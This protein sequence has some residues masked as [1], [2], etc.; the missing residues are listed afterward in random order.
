MK[1]LSELTLLFVYS[2]THVCVHTCTVSFS[3]NEISGFWNFR[4]NICYFEG[5]QTLI[6]LVYRAVSLYP[7]LTYSIHAVDGANWRLLLFVQAL[8]GTLSLAPSCRCRLFKLSTNLYI[9]ILQ[10]ISHI[11]LTPWQLH[12]WKYLVAHI[13]VFIHCHRKT[14]KICCFHF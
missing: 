11:F 10:W 13:Y 4:S 7:V 12:T 14:F 8:L 9:A 6:F 3:R 1:Y 5:F 2:C